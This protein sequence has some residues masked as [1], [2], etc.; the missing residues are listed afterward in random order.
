MNPKKF[1]SYLE[2]SFST[3]QMP[4]NVFNMEKCDT[5]T[6]LLEMVVSFD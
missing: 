1:Y 2:N 4:Q 3:L 5:K 6:P